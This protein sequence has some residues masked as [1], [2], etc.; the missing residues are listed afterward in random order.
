E[1]NPPQNRGGQ[2]QTHQRQLELI[3]LLPLKNTSGNYPEEF[4]MN[5]LAQRETQ[6]QVDRPSRQEFAIPEVDIF[7]T[8]DGYV[9]EAEM[10]GVNKDGLQVL[11]EGNELTLIGR[12]HTDTTPGQ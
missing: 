8:K 11:L 10:P 4:N 9:L 3:T 6:T 5:T 2:T 7:E 12:R 1:R